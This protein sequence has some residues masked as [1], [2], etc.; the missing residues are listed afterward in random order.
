MKQSL[1]LEYD[2]RRY[3]LAVAELF[4]SV[5]AAAAVPAAVVVDAAAAVVPLGVAAAFTSSSLGLG[6]SAKHKLLDSIQ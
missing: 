6:L 5:L 1:G 3:F 2:N 4:E